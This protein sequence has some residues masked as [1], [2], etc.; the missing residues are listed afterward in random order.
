MPLQK[1]FYFNKLYPLQ[2]EVLKVIA[3]CDTDFYLTGGTAL[4]RF[5]LQHRFSE[6]LDFFVNNVNDFS[7][8]VDRTLAAIK[9]N[10]ISMNIAKRAQDFVRI[11]CGTSETELKI[12]FVND[13]PYRSGTIELFDLFPRVDDWWNIL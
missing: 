13:I 3:G 5:Y 10:N 4:S 2:D 8:Q 12:D 9:N 6:D 1:E 11:Y 7:V